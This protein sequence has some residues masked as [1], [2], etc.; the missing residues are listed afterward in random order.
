[1]AIS[2]VSWL[3]DTYM[4]DNNPLYKKIPDVLKELK[5]DHYLA[6]YVPFADEQDIG[7]YQPW[8]DVILYGT[9]GYVKKVSKKTS[10]VPYGMTSNRMCNVYMTQIPNSWFLNSD[11]VIV[12]H[13]DL[14]YKKEQLFEMFQTTEIFM[15]PMSGDKSFT[16]KAVSWLDYA[17]E[18]D[19]SKQIEAVGEEELV[20]VASSKRDKIKGEF[21]FIIGA[22]EVIAG[23]EYRWDNI[24]DV[25]SDYPSECY[26]MAR[27]VA[28]L[29]WQLDTVYVCDVALMTEGHPKIVELNSFASAGWY[30]C[31]YKKIISR[32][33][34]IAEME[35]EGTL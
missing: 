21:R 9:I 15:R 23:S 20:L 34:E 31:D 28:R 3:I 13:G 16:G 12:P 24:L 4:F 11:Y 1:M 7:P 10:F 27:H 32:V 5:I 33:T 30:A 25:R 19:S 18:I 6:K 26:D 22:G 17:Y 35:L 2:K 29:P 14:I 8:D